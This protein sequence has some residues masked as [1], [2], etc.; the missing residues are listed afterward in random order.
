MEKEKD[1]INEICH[2]KGLLPNISQIKSQILSLYLKFYICDLV[3]V[4]LEI[5]C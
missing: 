3:C 2:G 4:Y 1:E 5:I